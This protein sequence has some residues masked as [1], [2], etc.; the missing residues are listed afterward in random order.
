[1]NQGKDE[2]M[3]KLFQIKLSPGEGVDS[4]NST[5]LLELYSVLGLQEHGS[6][7]KRDTEV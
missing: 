5:T 1:M 6:L 2:S 4:L 7:G 3:G